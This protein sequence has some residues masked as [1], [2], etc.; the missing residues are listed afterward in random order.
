MYFHVQIKQ[1]CKSEIL[2]VLFWCGRDQKGPGGAEIYIFLTVGRYKVVRVVGAPVERCITGMW[3]WRW[4][5]IL[6][7]F[8]D[9]LYYFSVYWLQSKGE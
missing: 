2:V 9:V 5:L 8:A 1:S 6:L 3:Y 4:L 7:D